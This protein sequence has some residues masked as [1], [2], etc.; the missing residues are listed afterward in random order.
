MANDTETLLKKNL[1]EVF[2]E[3][4]A[5]KRQA[6]IAAIWKEDGIFID[7]SGAHI[8]QAALEEAVAR[9][10]EQFP[11]FVFTEMG[12]AETYHG[13]GRLAW[14][15]GPP[16]EAPKVTGLDIVAVTD[17]RL[18]ALYTFLDSPTA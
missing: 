4:D 3:R 10:L 17:G 18:S 14:G 1:Y 7:P 16:N 12:R 13:I 6:A 2:G 5:G 15:F 11:G 8:G 9:L